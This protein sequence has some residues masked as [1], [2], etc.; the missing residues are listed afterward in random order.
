MPSENGYCYIQKGT[1]PRLRSLLNP[2]GTVPS[3]YGHYYIQSVQKLAKTVTTISREY[4]T[5]RWRSL[6][7]TEVTVPSDNGHY[8]IHGVQFL[9]IT[10]TTIS[11]VYS[12]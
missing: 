2:E 8:N 11:M 10:V 12:T 1:L 4:S 7:Y 6:L 3:D 9:A 5:K